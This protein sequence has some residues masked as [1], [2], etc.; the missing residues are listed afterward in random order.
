MC[1]TAS[2]L[3]GVKESF[4]ILGE[5]TEDTDLRELYDSFLGGSGG[6]FGGVCFGGISK[7]M[8][9]PAEVFNFGG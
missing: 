9:M 6:A 3:D 4:V 7:L 8:R 1:S 2:V 5:F